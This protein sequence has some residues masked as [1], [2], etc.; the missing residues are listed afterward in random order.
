VTWRVNRARASVLGWPRAILMQLAHP[1]IGAAIARH[2]TFR[3]T[4]FSPASRLHATVRA[5]LEL[6]FGTQEMAERAVERIRHIH[7]HV[8]G[9]TPSDAGRYRAGTVYS[10]HDPA[11]L[12]WVQLTLLDSVPRAYADLVAPLETHARDAYCAEA[13]LVAEPIGI[14]PGSLP[15]TDGE[16][17]LRIDSALG[18]GT[19]A[20]TDETRALGRALLS[21]PLMTLLLPATRVVRLLTVGWL[22]S[23]LR[24]GYGFEWTSRDA[25]AFD[26]WC[27]RSR[28]FHA[29]APDRLTVWGAA[30]RAEARH[31]DVVNVHP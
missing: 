9:A 19:L 7:D 6:T 3:E 2:S 10:A 31:I 18:D 27:R 5:M 17:R 29:T 30:R 23:A 12:T 25:L 22:P 13:R 1:L 16:V 24:S 15:G 14:P 8:Y 20:L 21:G 28:R 11:L 4:P 26:R